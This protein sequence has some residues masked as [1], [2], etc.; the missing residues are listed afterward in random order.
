MELPQLAAGPAVVGLMVRYLD[1]TLTFG[2]R[3]HVNY[4]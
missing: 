1:H 2:M 3:Q 4:Q